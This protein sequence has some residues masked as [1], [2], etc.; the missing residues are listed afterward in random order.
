MPN[1]LSV[2]YHI[3]LFHGLRVHEEV[4]LT[5]NITLRPLKQLAAFVDED[6][7]EDIAPEV[8]R[9][10]R[11]QS[12]GA[13]VQPFRWKPEFRSDLIPLVDRGRAFFNDAEDFVELLA[14][15]H[16]APVI[17][18]A[19]I[20]DCIHPTASYL[21]GDSPYNKSWRLAARP[22]DMFDGSIDLRVDALD[23]AR[24]TFRERQSDHYQYCAPIIARLAEALARS[25]RF[26]T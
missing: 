11:Q 17:C 24:K 8:M 7:L 3:A 12:L 23:E 13:L 26:Q 5:D 15:F 9:Y 14:L 10:N 20:P 25:G 18:L 22:F 21:L 4:Q 1:D 6:T 16:A 2:G 19:M